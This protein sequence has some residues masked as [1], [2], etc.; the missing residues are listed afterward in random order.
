MLGTVATASIIVIEIG[1]VGYNLHK[2][3]VFIELKKKL[4]KQVSSTVE[5]VIQPKLK[6]LTWKQS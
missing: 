3:G 1:L 2:Q 5:T 4:T 6:G